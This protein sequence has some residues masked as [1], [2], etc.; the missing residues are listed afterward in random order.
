MRQREPSQE[1]SLRPRSQPSS[2]E[3]SGLVGSKALPVGP[4]TVVVVVVGVAVRAD[5]RLLFRAPLL[6]TIT[7]A[8]GVQL[9]VRVLALQSL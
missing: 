9:F 2:G 8:A 1:R 5:G 6:T 7:I 3:S 4:D